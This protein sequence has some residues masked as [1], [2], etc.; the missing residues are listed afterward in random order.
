MTMFQQ[1]S[2]LNFVL[3]PWFYT[4]LSFLDAEILKECPQSKGKVKL[5]KYRYFEKYNLT[6]NLTRLY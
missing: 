2:D 4:N 5:L 1:V 3:C 6:D